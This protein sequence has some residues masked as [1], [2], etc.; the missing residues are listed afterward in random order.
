MTL[1]ATFECDYNQN[2]ITET[3]K[4]PTLTTGPIS[5]MLQAGNTFYTA[6]I[7]YNSV[8]KWM[9]LKVLDVSGNV[10]QGETFLNEF[11][12]NLLLASELKEYGL[13]YYP[14]LNIF[15]F[16]KLDSDWYNSLNMDYETLYKCITM[17]C[18]PEE[19][20]DS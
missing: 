5:L 14:R 3:A 17:Q 20:I 10:I 18:F 12:T 8:T 19:I 2:A 6:Q 7:L 11:P 13:F 4:F 1:I 15:K 9:T 16:Y